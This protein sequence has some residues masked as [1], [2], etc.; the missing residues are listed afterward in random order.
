[1]D[2]TGSEQCPVL[3]S[4]NRG[5][6]AFGSTRSTETCSSKNRTHTAFDTSLPHLS[7][8]LI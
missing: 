4:E 3:D 2:I 7:F 6:E 8:S 1:V 5:V